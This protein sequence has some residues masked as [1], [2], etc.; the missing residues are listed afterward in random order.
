MHQNT[1][2]EI[3]KKLRFIP[4]LLSNVGGGTPFPSRNLP[5]I[6]DILGPVPTVCLSLN[7]L[8]IPA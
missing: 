5:H 6:L 4:I 8:L 2:L 7:T 3:Q 1:H